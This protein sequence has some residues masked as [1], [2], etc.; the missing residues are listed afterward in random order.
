[1]QTEQKLQ[2]KEFALGLLA[3]QRL[4][5]ERLEMSLKWLKPLSVAVQFNHA[6]CG[7]Y[8]KHPT[9]VGATQT[10]ILQLQQGSGSSLLAPVAAN[11]IGALL[12]RHQR[13]TAGLSFFRVG[14]RVFMLSRFNQCLVQFVISI[15]I[16]V[17]AMQKCNE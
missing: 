1:V 12:Y 7:R 15:D 9:P 8:T 4:K 5:H 14:P 16:R 17:I 6:S 13:Q 10:R 3:H 2:A 11:F